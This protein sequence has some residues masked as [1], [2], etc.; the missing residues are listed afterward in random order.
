MAIAVSTELLTDA[1]RL[2]TEIRKRPRRWSELRAVLGDNPDR[3]IRAIDRLDGLS[4]IRRRKINGGT[5][6][7]AT[8]A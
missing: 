7:E 1:Q 4:A 8:S 6:F 3:L 2:L 5:H